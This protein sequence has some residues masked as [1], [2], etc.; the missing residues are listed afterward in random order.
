MSFQSVTF[1]TERKKFE[2]F[3]LAADIT[4]VNRNKFDLLI[5]LKTQGE[6]F[7]KI[8]QV[9]SSFIKLKF[10][11]EII[12]HRHFIDFKKKVSRLIVVIVIGF[13]SF[14]KEKGL[15]GQRNSSEG[16]RLRNHSSKVS[17]KKSFYRNW[18]T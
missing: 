13:A 12:V 5:L 8:N 11:N 1:W 7:L 3:R 18:C 14:F 6:T 2:L 10:L 9:Q 15:V 16:N 17:K 4:I